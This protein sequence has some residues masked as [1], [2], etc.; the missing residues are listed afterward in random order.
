MF[1]FLK[2]RAN[3]DKNTYKKRIIV[4]IKNILMSINGDKEDL[5]NLIALLYC[6]NN[7][8]T[9]EEK[10]LKNGDANDYENYIMTKYINSLNDDKFYKVRQEVEDLIINRKCN[11][12]D[13]LK[14]RD[15]KKYEL[16]E[17][18]FGFDNMP[19]KSNIRKPINR[20]HA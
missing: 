2:L 13:I 7:N 1:D 11:Y 10:A 4:T 15:Q 19:F 20:K 18:Q 5:I 9:K 17:K 6:A 16:L 8:L 14:E 12:E 3:E